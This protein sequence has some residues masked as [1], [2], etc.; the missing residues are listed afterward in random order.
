M[1]FPSTPPGPL[2]AQNPIKGILWMASAAL[3]FSLTFV[4]VRHLSFS[5]GAFE[6]TFFR[7]VIGILILLP[8]VIQRGLTSL[9]THQIGLNIV[10]NFAGNAGMSLSFLSMTLIP[11]GEAVTLH[12]S[13]PFFVILFAILILRERVGCIA[14]WPW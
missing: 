2:H 1:N 3:F 5:I 11:L 12:F 13:L 4:I 14:G 8:F 9:K 6:Q 7:H 10:R